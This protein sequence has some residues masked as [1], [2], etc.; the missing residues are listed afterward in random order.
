[1]NELRVRVYNVRFGDAIL[2]SLPDASN[3]G[4]EE[5]RHILID[6]G[7]SLGTE[8]GVD[9]VFEPVLNDVLAELDGQSLDLYI[10]THEHM[11]HVQGLQF[12]E[13]KVFPPKSLKNLLQTRFAWLT[14]SA[15]PGY[16]DSHPGAKKKLDEARSFM[17]GMERYL[18]A[19]PDEGT[20]WVRCLMA[21]NNPCSTE[22]CVSY[23]RELTANTSYV[24]R[25]FNTAGKHPFHEAKLHLWA[26]EEDTSIYYGRF[27]PVSFGVASGG[28][29]NLRPTLSTPQPPPGV[30][31]GAFYNLVEQRR[32]GMGDNLLTI[33]KAANNTSVVLCL[34][35]RGW[36]LLF[37]GDAEQ[38]SWQEMD[39]QSQLF[40]VDFLKI[41]HHG[42]VTGTPPPNLLDKIL[43][44]DG[45]TRYAVLSSYP[46]LKKLDTEK[47]TYKDV[48][49]RTVLQELQRRAQLRCTVE[50]PD[51]GYIDYHFEGNTRNVSVLTSRNSPSRV[52]LSQRTRARTTSGKRELRFATKG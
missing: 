45:V 51:G 40:P 41:S 39:K 10:M 6:V 7:N 47:W 14:N 33:D 25:T 32:L 46:Y 18:S 1:M 16:Y 52:S 50:V 12:G 20:D 23:L 29:A 8:G 28:K 21:L 37:P 22:D 3:G 31:A 38:R 13:Q 17:R 11:D 27:Q 24:H 15:Q 42:S 4:T 44:E 36:K 5:L 43:P 35:W 9:T 30:D 26:P 48:P 34:E 2:I 19:A 49:E